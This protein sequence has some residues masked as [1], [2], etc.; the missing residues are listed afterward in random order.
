MSLFVK[1]ERGPPNAGCQRG[2]L[3][4]V[5]ASIKGPELVAE[6]LRLAN[7]GRSEMTRVAA[8]RELLDRA[9]GRPKMSVEGEV[10]FGVS[11]ELQ[12]LFHQHDG[13]SRSSP[14]RTNVA[15]RWGM[16]RVPG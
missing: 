7:H 3:N 12:R 10:L 9:Y 1:G 14:V 13:Q 5:A 16:C 8:A 6:L 15:P 4:K 2:T 11:A